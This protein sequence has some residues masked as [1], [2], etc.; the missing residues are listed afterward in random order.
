MKKYVNIASIKMDPPQTNEI[1]YRYKLE[2]DLV[3]REAT[4]KNSKKNPACYYDE[5]K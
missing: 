4:N 1:E 5:P 2:I 3:A